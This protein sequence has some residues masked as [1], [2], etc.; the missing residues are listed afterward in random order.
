MQPPRMHEYYMRVIATRRSGGPTMDEARAH[1]LHTI[2][3]SVAP[4]PWPT[5][6]GWRSAL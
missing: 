3:A 1:Y 5:A 6:W 2:A 4:G